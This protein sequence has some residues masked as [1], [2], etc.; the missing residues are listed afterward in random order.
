MTSEELA[1]TKERLKNIAGLPWKIEQSLADSGRK[2]VLSHGCLEVAY[3]IVPNNAEFIA[4]APSDI[5]RLLAEVEWIK[6]CFVANEKLYK[7]EI[8]QLKQQSARGGRTFEE[9][10]DYVQN[11]P[12]TKATREYLK[13]K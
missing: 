7:T 12:E 11:K 3:S 1:A 13:D 9:A 2:D 5:E 8:S 4:N 6:A 10:R